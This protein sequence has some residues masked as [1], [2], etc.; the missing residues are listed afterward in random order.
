MVERQSILSMNQIDHPALKLI[1]HVPI[2]SQQKKKKKAAGGRLSIH[3]ILKM[4]THLEDIN[5]NLEY[6]ENMKLLQERKSS[7]VKQQNKM[8]VPFNLTSQSQILQNEV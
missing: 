7:E 6:E 1:S 5:E 3:P 2:V 4:S 8:K